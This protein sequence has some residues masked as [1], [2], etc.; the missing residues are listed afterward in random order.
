MQKI[1]KKVSKQ[2][3]NRI[4]VLYEARF[5]SIFGHFPLVE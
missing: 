2:T 5:E 3:E 4:F 1:I